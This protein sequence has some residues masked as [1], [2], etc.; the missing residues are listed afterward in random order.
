MIDDL[1]WARELE[2]EGRLDEAEAAYAAAVAVRERE[3]ESEDVA[4]VL[5]DL[6]EVRLALGR[7]VDAEAAWRRGLAIFDAHE[8]LPDAANALGGLARLLVATDR[9]EE[10]L[11]AARRMVDLADETLAADPRRRQPRDRPPIRRQGWGQRCEASRRLGDTR[12][13]TPPLGASSI[14]RPRS[15]RPTIRARP[16][17]RTRSG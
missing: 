3:G 9:F 5:L 15:C 13:R 16:R 4:V 11:E 17:R 2:A 6:A 12:A 10:A 8:A 1:D 7:Y 14:S